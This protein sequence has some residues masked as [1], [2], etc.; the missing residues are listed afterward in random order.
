[1]IGVHR[2]IN[3]YGYLIQ[4]FKKEPAGKEI[5]RREDIERENRNGEDRCTRI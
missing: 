1:M 4:L 2:D 3:G 5:A